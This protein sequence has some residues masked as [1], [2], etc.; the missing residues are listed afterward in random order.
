MTRQSI[1]PKATP[2]GDGTYYDHPAYAKIAASRVQGQAHLYGS[3]F[4]HQHFMTITISRSR[5]KRELSN[6]WEF[7]GEELIEVMLSDAQWATFVSTPN[8]GSGVS[9]TINHIEGKRVPLI[10]APK[11]TTAQFK[12]E[13][14]Q[15]MAEMQED[16][17]RLA[18]ELDG[19]LGKTKAKQIQQSLDRLADRLT[20]STAFVAKQFD[21]HME[22]TVEKA[23]IEINAHTLNLS[24]Q[25][26][27]DVLSGRA[28]AIAQTVSPIIYSPVAVSINDSTTDSGE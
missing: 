3:D 13:I 16:I 19:P 28:P 22:R 15:T 18:A 9:C 27:F 24:Q 21:E 7:G 11:E 17:K 4:A 25:V 6:D 10:A 5:L 26:G 12:D 1:E 2:E 8:A 20:N 14:R 23:K